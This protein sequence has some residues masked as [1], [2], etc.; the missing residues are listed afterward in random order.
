[1]GLMLNLTIPIEGFMALRNA[2]GEERAVALAR[3]LEHAQIK[4]EADLAAKLRQDWR[5]EMA[6][7]I[8]PFARREELAEIR[9]QIAQLPTREELKRFATHE[10]LADLRALF[11]RLDKKMTVGFLTLLGLNLASSAPTFLEWGVKVV[12]YAL[13]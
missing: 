13:K 9:N 7:M 2:V 6:T 11:M 10:D 8:A 5:N 3:A 12:G 1:M 4:G